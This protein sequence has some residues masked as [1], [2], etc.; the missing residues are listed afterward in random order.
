MNILL[1]R[2]KPH[3]TTIGLQSVMI[4]EPLE[5][6]TLAAVLRANGHH[7]T[8]LDMILERRPLKHF[9]RKHQPDLVGITGY[10]SHI[11]VI[12]EYARQIKME[13]V[14]TK[15][16]VGGVH[17]AVCPEDFS[18]PYID[19]VCRTAEDFY[20]FTGCTD[21]A[22]RLPDRN[23]PE[24]YTQKYYYLFQTQCALIKT[25]FGCPNDCNFC[26]CK[27]I[28]P[29]SAR[30]VDDVIAELLAM[31]QTEVYIVDDNFLHNRERLLE[32][33]D[34]LAQNNIK[35]HFLCYG[36][37]DFI[38]RNEDIIARL[39]ETGLRAVIVGLESASQEELDSYDKR[40]NVSDNIAAVKILQKYGIEC[41]A[42][43]I[44][45]ID[46]GKADFARLYRFLNELGIIFV[47]LQP[48]TPMPG[49]PY[50]DKFKERL[51]IP[52]S[53]PEKWD[54]AHLVVRPGKLS[55]RQ[56]YAQIIKL[57]YKIT[58]T[59]KHT[60]YMLRRY[61][62]KRTMKLSVGALRI[63]LQYFAKIIRG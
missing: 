6:M 35:K 62:F 22:P 33:A 25:S 10:I 48:F 17:A 56:Y 27:E 7:V 18:D 46:W 12:K 28:E 11:G 44:L 39:Y 23:L 51:I 30:S 36:R 26:F 32:F 31:P 50:F 40:T 20:R 5:L 45:G 15:V 14:D 16:C 60:A 53:Q 54:M 29:Y 61:G 37:A 52:Y 19:L 24:R 58:I 49:T 13:N 9:L 4:C 21:C 2:S 57:Y 43:V 55:V 41:Y 8:I 63:S 38:A 34:K 42:T 1:V 59:P 3:R 47:N